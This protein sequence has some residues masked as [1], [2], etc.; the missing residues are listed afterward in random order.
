MSAPLYPAF[1]SPTYADLVDQA[2]RRRDENRKSGRTRQ[3]AME[4]FSE[5]HP[6]IET[7]VAELHRVN[8]HI[9]VDE[10]LV[11]EAVSD[12][13]E[14]GKQLVQELKW[15]P[16][17]ISVLPQGSSSTR[18]LI[19]SPSAEKFDID[20]VCKVILNRHEVWDPIA[21]FDQFKPALANRKAIAKNRCWRIEDLNSRYYVEF[22]PSV[23]MK[24]IPA[25][26]LSLDRQLTPTRYSDSALAV[27][28]RATQ[29]WKPS[30]P[31][32]MTQWVDDQ[33][34][35][36]LV[37]MLFREAAGIEAMDSVKPVPDQSVPLS[38]TL[39]VAIR[40]FKRHRDMMVDRGELLAET[41]PI[42]I[43]IVTLLTQCYEGLADKG[44]TYHNHIE[45]LSD[46][47]DLMPYMVEIRAGMWWVE[48]P[49]VAGENFAERWNTDSGER[50]C[51]F[52][53]WCMQLQADLLEILQAED[54]AAL[55]ERVRR[56][57]GTTSAS[58]P[59]PP[60]GL[61]SKAPSSVIVQPAKQGLA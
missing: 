55:A 42:S 29:K 12:Y 3:L 34:K 45:L 14:I 7:V 44:K 52:D 11:S 37:L 25:N 56:A 22:T 6:Y 1:Q 33:S 5:E 48:N 31:E 50:K 60:K 13:E 10:E 36:N 15:E 49:T 54:K 53:Q 38:D 20:A 32:G 8:E 41:K 61:A 16:D 23:P 21:F 58:A 47:V 18:T 4:A 24:L 39:R 35:R 51:A 26:L 40:L 2:V 46:L 17:D 27:V 28:D 57:F 43:L 30:N 19:R 59:T 9:S